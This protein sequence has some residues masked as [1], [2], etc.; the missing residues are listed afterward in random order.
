[1]REQ[2]RL[3]AKIRALRR[4]RDMTQAGLAVRLGISASYL[5]LIEHDRRAL[6]APLLIKLAQV[7]E[8]DLKTF[9]PDSDERTIADLMEVF[10]DAIFDGHSLSTTDVRE[11]CLQAPGVSRAV[12]ALY[13]GYREVQ[14]TSRELSM[15]MSEQSDHAGL[16]SWRLP[17]EEVTELL[18]RN[19]NYIGVLET[20]AEE[21]WEEASL[22]A[23]DLWGGLSRFLR[24]KHGVDVRLVEADA[25]SPHVRHYDPHRRL[26]VISEVLPPPSRVFQLA[27][28]VAL[29]TRGEVLDK[30]VDDPTLTTEDST[31]L[32]RVVAANYFAGAVMMPYERFRED[33]ERQRYD[34]EMLG[35]R[36]RASFE[37]VCH[38]LT[39]LGRPGHEGIPFH[40]VRL[41]LA[42]NISKRYS[43]SG[44]SLARFSGLCPRWNVHA[45]FQNPGAVRVQV[46]QT[47][48]KENW[49]SFART[50]NPAPGG[51][52]TARAALAVALGCKVEYASKM[53]YSDGLDL[54]D[55]NAAVDIGVSCRMCERTNCK[56]RAFPQ[57]QKPLSID[58]NVRGLSFFST[59][60]SD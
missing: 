45:A 35:L 34:A 54:K 10:G 48:D 15:R 25:S 29:L 59:R 46:S 32:G 42:G 31:A 3:G 56:Q 36:F 26:L 16:E 7:L 23:G 33:S 17:S 9:A 43:G 50:V 49:F 14:D 2:A 57:L 12:L 30:V 55:P 19:R 1:M 24:Q 13:E 6:T 53:V 51:F 37:Q 60:S 18:Q 44:M 41:D 21:L 40:F 47:P 20:A 27:H 39:T 11:F 22:Q 28:Q 4:G 8:I 38:R 58:V 5:N 52:R